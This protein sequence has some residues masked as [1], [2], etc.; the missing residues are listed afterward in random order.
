MVECVLPWSSTDSLNQSPIRLSTYSSSSGCSKVL[1]YI[2]QGITMKENSAAAVS[3]GNAPVSMPSTTTTPTTG[4]RQTIGSVVPL[5]VD[6]NHNWPSSIMLLFSRS[7]KQLTA[8]L[9]LL[10]KRRSLRQSLI[11]PLF[12][13]N[14]P[15][16]LLSW[17]LSININSNSNSNSSSKLTRYWE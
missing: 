14:R 8:S 2:D 3:C 15:S 9:V 10:P 6:R 12:N 4:R 16:T 1:G 11:S 13:S 17:L 7:N 5:P